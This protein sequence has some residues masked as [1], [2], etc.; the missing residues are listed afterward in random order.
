MAEDLKITKP[1]ISLA[2]TILKLCP[3][4][5]LLESRNI[6]ILKLTFC[7]NSGKTSIKSF[8]S[9]KILSFTRLKNLLA[10]YFY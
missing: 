2:D 3:S 8:F 4:I 9:L 1:E 5:T 6:V 7:E 10:D